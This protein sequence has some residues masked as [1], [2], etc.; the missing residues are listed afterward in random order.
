MVVLDNGKLK[1]EISEKGAE[2][3]RV[4][5]NGKD[6][7]WSGDASVW[8]GVAP[9]LFPICGALKDG[10]F[11]YNE[12]EYQIC[13]HGFARN[14]EFMIEK[15]DKKS[16]T[17]LLKQNN[18]TLKMYPWKFEFRIKY[19]LKG[20]SIK[21]KYDIKNNADK[22]MYASVGSHEAYACD[23]GIEDYDIIFEKR[24]SF[25]AHYVLNN[26]I[27]R[28]TY[29]VLENQKVLPLLNKYFE[30]DA[31]V[32]TDLKSRK[33]TLRNKKT[34]EKVSVSFKGFD[35]LL[36]WTKMGAP[37]ICIEPWTGIPSFVDE[38]Y[39][40]TKKESISLIKPNKNMKKVHKIKF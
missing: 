40:I 14:S 1:V 24:E 33:A 16:V 5:Y 32:F 3:R 7:F 22:N 36:I 10:K 27:S 30:I 31:L 20:D 28:E 38:G 21:V 25:N 12:Q 2:I 26:G 37:Y 9:V 15:Q 17:F 8:S 34:G 19:I 13:K 23:G 11:I 18:E 29:E 39:D 35:N 4:I 6:R